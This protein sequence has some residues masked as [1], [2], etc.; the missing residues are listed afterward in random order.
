MLLINLT[1]G[2]PDGGSAGQHFIRDFL[3][4]HY[5]LTQREDSP[6]WRHCAA[7]EIPHTL[8]YKIDHFL[9][10]GRLVTEGMEPF[11]NQCWLAVHIGQLNWPERHDP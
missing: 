3:I 9:R 7:M 8:Q 2:G 10:Y 5:R 11:G 6:L 1:P 4:L